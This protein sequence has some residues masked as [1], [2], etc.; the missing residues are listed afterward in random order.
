MLQPPALLLGSGVLEPNLHH[1]ERQVELGAD[2]LTLH[3]IRVG[4][5][6]VTGLQNGQLEAGQVCSW[7][8]A[9]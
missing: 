5:G 1:L 3:G 2:R 8:T 7:P 4:A 6:L 9:G